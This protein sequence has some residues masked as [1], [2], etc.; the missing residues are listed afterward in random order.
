MREKGSNWK[1]GRHVSSHGYVKFL[2]A[3]GDPRADSKGYAY[4]HRIVAEEKIGRSLETDE[5]V[6]HINGMRVD[7]RPENIM[8]VPKREHLFYHRKENCN[9][10]LLGVENLLR[11]CECGC[12]GQFFTYDKYNRPR[13]YISGHNSQERRKE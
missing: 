9:L 6:H 13:K 5:T 2:L 3:P 12:G 8:V 11:Q 1:G 7:N 4:E 10:R